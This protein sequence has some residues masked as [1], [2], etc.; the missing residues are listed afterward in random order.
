MSILSQAVGG[1]NYIVN[2]VELYIKS[3]H[4]DE[5]VEFLLEGKKDLPQ[6]EQIVLMKRLIKKMLKESI[7]EVTEEELNDSV[8]L[9]TLL[10]FIDI[11]YEV[12]GMTD[13][14][15]ISRAEKIKSAIE[16]RREAIARAQ[17]GTKS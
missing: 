11:F 9:G 12:S 4:V 13:E 15:N 3:P 10:T 14:E 17:S 5:D 7:P 16:Q 1:K 8:R 6:K 2:G